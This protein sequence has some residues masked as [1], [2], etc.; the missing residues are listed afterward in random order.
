MRAAGRIAYNEPG[1]QSDGGKD[2]QH[3]PDFRERWSA[4]KIT[5]AGKA[6][7]G[8]WA[9]AGDRG[10]SLQRRASVLANNS[11]WRARCHDTRLSM[12]EACLPL[13]P[14][15]T[16]ASHALIDTR[17]G[18]MRYSKWREP[19]RTRGGESIAR[20]AGISRSTR[21]VDRYK[22]MVPTPLPTRSRGGDALAWRQRSSDPQTYPSRRQLFSSKRFPW[23][24]ISCLS[25]MS[26]SEIRH[27]PQSL[28]RIRHTGGERN[29]VRRAG[30][31][32]N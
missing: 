9:G 29:V 20:R 27:Y 21:N 16:A 3:D 26:G 8:M 6:D 2:D 1:C 31:D 14:S 5:A 18:R 30:M 25:V 23:R 32:L 19:D 22:P 11:P 7:R 24:G 10:A 15:V 13:Y 28:M 4:P 12:Y 17:S